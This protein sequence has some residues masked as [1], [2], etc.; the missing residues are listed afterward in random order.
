MATD[1]AY[2]KA[3]ATFP[4]LKDLPSGLAVAAYRFRKEQIRGYGVR[5]VTSMA[6]ARCDPQL[7][8]GIEAL[9]L[10]PA[11]LPFIEIQNECIV[12]RLERPTVQICPDCWRLI[13]K[14]LDLKGEK[15]RA[16]WDGWGFEMNLDLGPL[17][18]AIGES[19]EGKGLLSRA[20]ETA[21]KIVSVHEAYRKGFRA[22]R[23]QALKEK[24][25]NGKGL[26]SSDNK[27]SS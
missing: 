7:D 21:K 18:K 2:E 24:H 11:D 6:N 4:D 9:P 10:L 3:I 14:C 12:C 23:A 15:A 8:K 27:T 26:F 13:R 1:K 5:L 16:G 19:D 25:S 20:I 17:V 22:G